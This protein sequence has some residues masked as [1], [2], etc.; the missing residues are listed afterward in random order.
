MTAAA[1]DN[2]R[3]RPESHL[4]ERAEA[5]RLSAPAIEAFADELPR[6]TKEVERLLRECIDGY[7]GRAFTV[8]SL[9]ALVF[10]TARNG[11][12]SID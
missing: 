11:L 6:D 4:V 9:A 7:F 2:T 3:K 5:V 10:L 1:R 8:V 12:R